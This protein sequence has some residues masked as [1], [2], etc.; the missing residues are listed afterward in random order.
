MKVGTKAHV[1]R[2]NS[3]T[4]IMTHVVWLYAWKSI[5]SSGYDVMPS[6]NELNEDS[7]TTPK[8]L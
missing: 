2:N 1:Y 7:I 4:V 6:S 5:R 8:S 3:R